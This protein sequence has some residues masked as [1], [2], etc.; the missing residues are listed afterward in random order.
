MSSAIVEKYLLRALA[1]VIGPAKV[2][3]LLVMVLGDVWLEL[4]IEIIF[5]IP[6]HLF[7][8]SLIIFWKK[9]IKIGFFYSIQV[10]LI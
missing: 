2:V 6:F 4:F 3:L 5:F 7:F 8:R 1:I 9:H 10:V